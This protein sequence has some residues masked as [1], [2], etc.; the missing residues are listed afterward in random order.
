[1]RFIRS[2]VHTIDP[3]GES[4]LRITYVDESGELK[5][6]VFDMVV[7]SVGFE[8]AKE[9]VELT[10]RLC[11]ELNEHKFAKT[12]N[13]MPVATSRAGVYVCGTIRSPKNIPQSVMEASGAAAASSA[14]LS[15][16][17]RTENKTKELPPERDVSEEEPR[18]GVFVCNCGINIGGIVDVPGVREYA[19][20]LNN[21]VHVEDNLFT[22]SQDTQVRMGE[23]IKEKSINR[24]VVAACTPLT[25]EALFRET[26]LDVGINKYL[27]DMANIR[28]QDSWVHMKDKKAATDKAKDLVRM[29]V[30]RAALL[31]PL[32]EKKVEINQRG[33]VIGGGVAGLNT[34]LNLDQQGYEVILVEKESSYFSTKHFQ[35]S[36][37]S[38]E[39]ASGIFSSLISDLNESSP[40]AAS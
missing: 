37:L 30:A 3:E 21:V 15:E 36:F 13:F 23:I 6:E 20:S 7:L 26:L 2:R 29:S 12:D 11:I 33:L 24:M 34:A 9:T 8:V 38:A 17:C 16:L 4:D 39:S 10:N 32:H 18:V 31:R 22:C 25:H 35:I 27:F 28:N 19:R 1:M 14:L 5:E 40:T